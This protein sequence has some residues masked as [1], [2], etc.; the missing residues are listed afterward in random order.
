LKIRLKAGER[1]VVE[2]VVV[3]ELNA[4]DETLAVQA[5]VRR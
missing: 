2:K 4:A 5:D 3:S 1:L